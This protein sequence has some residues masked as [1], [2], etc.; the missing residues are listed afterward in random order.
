MTN[1]DQI[2]NVEIYL[3]ALH[4]IWNKVPGSYELAGTVSMSPTESEVALKHH[5]Q[6]ILD[7]WGPSNEE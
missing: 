7:T 1:R 5:D 4:G 3:D 6:W 2:A